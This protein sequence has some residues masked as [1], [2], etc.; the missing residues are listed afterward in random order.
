MERD[1]SAIFD[2]GVQSGWIPS[3]THV[4]TGLSDGSTYH[5]RV[6]ARNALNQVASDW[7]ASVR[8]TQDASAPVL[9]F[10]RASGTFTGEA[11]VPVTVD[12]GDVSG[13]ASLVFTPAGGAAVNA[14]TGVPDTLWSASLNSLA[15]GLNS[16]TVTATDN[17]SPPHITTETWSITRLDEAAVPPAGQLSPVLA[18][19]FNV[20]ATA[21]DAMAQ[22]V[23]ST[24]TSVLA[25]DGKTYLTISFRRRIQAA[26]FTYVVE[27]S[28]DMIDWDDTGADIIEES[29]SPVGDGLME[30]C[31]CRITPSIDIAGRKFVRVRVDLD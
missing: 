24:G 10:S 26:G 25:G 28:D 9:V 16:F 5:Y 12:V 2:N 21:A 20:N 29:V 31:T 27:T 11:V 13:L 3:T 7:S 22:T 15:L 18:A 14:S 4:F 6:R 23:P 1:T 8:S 30:I 19:A 17:A